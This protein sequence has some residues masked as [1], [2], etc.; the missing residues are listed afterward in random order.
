MQN[1]I[2]LNSVIYVLSR[3]FSICVSSLFVNARETNGS[4]LN[5]SLCVIIK[6][7]MTKAW[8]L[9]I[10][11]IAKVKSKR[12]QIWLASGSRRNCCQKGQRN[13]R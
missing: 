6:V 12:S 9:F 5:G 13:G 3:I 8:S 1:Q 11:I 10:S 7:I 2:L 4:C